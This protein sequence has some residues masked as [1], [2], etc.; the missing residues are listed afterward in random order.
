MSQNDHC[1]QKP[2]PVLLLARLMLLYSSE[3]RTSWERSSRHRRPEGGDTCSSGG[4]G[5]GEARKRVGSARAGSGYS[6]LVGNTT[7]VN[8]SELDDVIV[9]RVGADLSSP[10]S[11]LINIED[12]RRGR[13]MRT[14]PRRT[15]PSPMDPPPLR[16]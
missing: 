1:W 10:T 3:I 9:A 16:V 7:T 8:A 5:D 12:S 15:T 14:L 11:L 6:A 4:G 2:S 13:C